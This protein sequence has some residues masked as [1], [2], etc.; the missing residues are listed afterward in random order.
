VANKVAEL[1]MLQLGREVC[2]ASTEDMARFDRV[3]DELKR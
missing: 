3:N 1:M 2:C